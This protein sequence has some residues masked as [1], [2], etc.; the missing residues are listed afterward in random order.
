LS[1]RTCFGISVL[2]FKNFGFKASLCGRGSLLNRNVL[3]RK[4]Y[5]AIE[6][7]QKPDSVFA[8]KITIQTSKMQ[9]RN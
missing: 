3:K 8:K 5:E 2:G 6:A 9:K 7:M 4:L 1:S